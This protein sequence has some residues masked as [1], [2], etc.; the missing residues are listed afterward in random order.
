MG[1]HAVGCQHAA[2]RCIPERQ[3]LESVARR[4]LPTFVVPLRMARAGRRGF[5][6]PLWSAGVAPGIPP[7]P[8]LSGSHRLCRGKRA[9][10][11]V[12]AD[13]LK[14]FRLARL[15]RSTELFLS[16]PLASDGIG[17]QI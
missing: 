13:V 9:G 15:V 1:D 5:S 14:A 16:R 12:L 8:L 7:V 4:L 11:P 6:D 10:L 3:T 17:V 2:K